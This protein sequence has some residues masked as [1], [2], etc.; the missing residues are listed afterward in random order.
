MAQGRRGTKRPAR[1]GC[2]A[3][4][5]PPRPGP[6]AADAA[7]H[8]DAALA[9]KIAFLRC[10]T[11]YPEGTGA[12][13]ARETRMSWVFLTDAFAYKLKKPVAS[14]H[15]D[16]SSLALRRAF[17]EEEVRLNA[18]L[19]PSIY[20]GVVALR[21]GPDGRLRI[22][23]RGGGGAAVDWLVKMRRLP[24]ERMLDAAI[25]DGAVERTRIAAVADL[26]AAFYAR[27]EPVPLGQAE[28]LG[29]FLEDQATNRELLH[30]PV[31]G[32]PSAVVERVLAPVD[33][34]LRDEPHL[35]L[36][37]LVARRIVEGHGDLRPEHVFLGDPVAVIDCLE[38]SRR[39]RL[40]D[41]FEE[42]AFL[43]VECTAAGAP[44][45]GPAVLARCA[46]RLGDRPPERLLAFYAAFRAALR[47]R[48]A[49]AHLLDPVPRE[50]AKWLPQARRYLAVGAE[51]AVTLHAPAGR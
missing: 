3:S 45:I 27:A 4:G 46:A 9:E 11:S 50:A 18:R 30:A 6:A 12:V 5:A 39:L 15:L 13:E 44:H 37:R 8:E 25:R 33:A 26:L 48:Q 35:L 19:A 43:G 14:R 16:F 23:S 29:R 22:E 40:L 36:D 17:C 49:V 24:A 42:L 31:F 1:H 47:A 21:R 2:R 10:P 28:Y 7:G 32:L 20:L 34:V 41:P 38:F 51:A